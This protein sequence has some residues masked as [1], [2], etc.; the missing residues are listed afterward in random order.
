MLILLA[1]TAVRFS[2]GCNIYDTFQ[3]CQNNECIIEAALNALDAEEYD[4]AINLLSPIYI[5]DPFY[6]RVRHLIASGY[7][8]KA[9]FT[10]FEAVFDYQRRLSYWASLQDFLLKDMI[11]S[12]EFITEATAAKVYNIDSAFTI[13]TARSIY[14]NDATTRDEDTNMFLGFIALARA[15]LRSKILVDADNDEVVT[16]INPCALAAMSEADTDAIIHSMYV[17]FNSISNT[18]AGQTGSL[19]NFRM[20]ADLGAIFTSQGTTRPCQD[21]GASATCKAARTILG[22]RTALTSRIGFQDDS[23]GAACP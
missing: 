1:L 7:A 14:P 21:N 16:L 3:S 13:L 12:P 10:F 18:T 9:G 5:S 23:G 22:G 8:G 2:V 11:E 15:H 6:P 19:K 4:T 17:F 20:P